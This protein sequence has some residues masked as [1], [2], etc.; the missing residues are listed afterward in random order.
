M[1]KI[2]IRKPPN[3]IAGVLLIVSC[4]FN[5]CFPWMN[6]DLG[7]LIL[8]PQRLFLLAGCV[9]CAIGWICRIARKTW[10]DFLKIRKFETIVFAFYALWSIVGVAWLIFGTRTEAAQTEVMGIITICLYEF[11]FFSLTETKQDVK[12]FL[13]V[14]VGCGILLA[15]M[16]D[17]E[18]VTG[19]FVPE[20]KFYFT[21]EERLALE[22]RN[23][24]PTTV[25]YNPNDFAA[26]TL[27]CLS[28]LVYRLIRAETKKELTVNLA[29]L[30]V[31]LIPVP[32][33]NSTIFNLAFALLLIIAIMLVC[34]MRAKG[35]LWKSLGA[36]AVSIVYYF[37]L[38]A[39]VRRVDRALSILYQNYLEKKYADL[40][41]PTLPDDF[42]L[43]DTDTLISQIETAIEGYGTIHIRLW[44][45]KAGLDFFSQHPLIGCG[46]GGFAR[47]MRRNL[48]YYT[49][50]RGNVN[51]HNV[52]I[53]VLAQYGIIIFLLYMGLLVRMLVQAIRGM[54]AEI[55]LGKAGNGM[56]AFLILVMFLIAGILPSS[57]MRMF[58]L[59]LFY[60]FAVSLTNQKLP[61]SKPET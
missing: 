29:I 47:L 43:E 4:I 12:F 11:C 57:I 42:V 28:I 51:P 24:A 60:I 23:F 14:C 18:I 53:E 13:Q 36:A 21:L 34:R 8:T 22:N 48:E 32:I 10:R 1:R 16:A 52:Y 37:P 5:A 50:T 19:S 2:E 17:V 58:A 15:L 33:I 55:R 44:L 49:E 7:V 27:M 56:L 46:P 40:P 25:F 31:L 54:K 38:S 41:I 20:T 6:I 3:L 59:W 35:R 39:L 26:Y 30:L 9:Y 45:M 61:E